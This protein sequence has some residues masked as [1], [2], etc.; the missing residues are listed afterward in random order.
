MAERYRLTLAAG[1][2]ALVGL[3]GIIAWSRASAW[4]PSPQ[5]YPFQGIDL[6]ENP[7]AVE[8]SSV[9]ANG[10]GFAYIVATAGA[11]RRDPSFETNWQAIGDAGLRRGAVHLYSLC[12]A[13]EPQANAFNTLVARDPGALPAAV[14]VA[15]RDDCTATPDRD[16]LVADLARFATIVETHT[17]KPILLRV[18]RAIERH[19]GLTGA[20]HRPIWVMA[21]FLAPGYAARPWTLWRATDMRRIDG[22]EQPVNWDVV[23]P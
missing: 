22:L 12:Q 14:D 23:A 6:P 4:A 2:L 7:P 17:G 19:Y 11:D 20:L 18:S 9:R 1:V 13:A 8:W 15:Y 21:D 16:A 5:H 10:A 3:L